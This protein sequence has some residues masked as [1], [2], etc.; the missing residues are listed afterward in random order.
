MA[1]HLF[2]SLLCPRQKIS[3]EQLTTDINIAAID[4]AVA[5]LDRR[6]FFARLAASGAGLMAAGIAGSATE[7]AA[8]STA[9][10]IVDVLNFALNLE[11]LEA[12]LYAAASAQTP[13]AGGSVT[14]APTGLVLDAQTAA[15][16][17]GLYEDEMHHIALLQSAITSLGG[18]PIAQPAIDFTAGGKMNIT[19]QAQFLAVARQFTTVGNSAYAGGAQF[20][21]S[22]T[23]VLTTAGQILG[24][25]G[26]HLGAVNY[27]CCLQGV[28]S[29][30]VDA[31]D[32]P[33]V[34]PNTFFTVTPTNATTGSALGP[35]RDTSQVLGIV[36]GVSTATT[37][38]PSTGVTKGGFFP[39]GVN[40]T[41]IS[42]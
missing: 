36:Y 33:P 39:N 29:P 42:T 3:E 30:A 6:R 23:S 34:P 9:P 40:G 13:P 17:L 25:E 7:A 10:T 1:Q 2:T 27:L 19:T 38:T 32:Y 15:T 26:Q 5:T 8:Q 21:V 11:F 37:S 20:L 24:A 4:R 41:I 12:N 22:N 35:L 16:A 14:G 18:T 31:L 28:M